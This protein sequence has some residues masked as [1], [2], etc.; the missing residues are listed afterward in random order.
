MRGGPAGPARPAGFGGHSP[1]Q[2]SRVESW[3]RRLF[4][5]KGGVVIPNLH[6]SMHITTDP[7][8]GQEFEGHI[9]QGILAGAAGIT[10]QN[11]A[12]EMPTAMLWNPPG[13]AILLTV[14]EFA[15]TCPTV[16][17]E[18]FYLTNAR[19]VYVTDE[20]NTASMDTRRYKG[21]PVSVGALIGSGVQGYALTG[22]DTIGVS[23]VPPGS[24]LIKRLNNLQN[25]TVRPPLPIL[26]AP[27]YGLLWRTAIV[28]VVVHWNFRF[29]V[30]T[31]EPSELSR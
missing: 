23:T 29:R 20:V 1:I 15:V 31:A 26:L 11:V 5:A 8:R 21:D 18:E 12:G 7:F 22:T 17:A 4:G 24:V 6:P 27:G 2:I 9:L 14:E 25:E 13:S 16:F 30:R 10:I 19:P 3:G 28:N